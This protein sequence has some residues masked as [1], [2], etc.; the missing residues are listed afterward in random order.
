MP[1]EA[2][3]M[4]QAFLNRPCTAQLADL[5][6]RMRTAGVGQLS[7]QEGMEFVLVFGPVL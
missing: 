2:L 1:Q 6:M 4:G 5:S 7:V 3:K